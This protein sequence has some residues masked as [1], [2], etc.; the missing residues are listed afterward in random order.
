MT[1]GPKKHVAL[2]KAEKALE[3][4]FAE[5]K[6]SPQAAQVFDKIESTA[7]DMEEQDVPPDAGS[8]N[9]LKQAEA[10][11]VAADSATAQDRPAAVL[12][13]AAVQVATAPPDKRGE[14]DEAIGKAST[15][16]A[17]AESPQAGRDEAF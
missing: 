16:P 12:V 15:S 5:V 7:G 17:T 3:K 13:N 2:E 6:T 4:G 10:I 1:N 9:P 11:K 14:L 8:A